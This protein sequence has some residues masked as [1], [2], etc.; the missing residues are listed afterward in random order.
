MSVP[1]WLLEVSPNSYL[2]SR[3]FSAV[4]G[5]PQNELLKRVKRG[6]APAPTLSHSRASAHMC[7][8]HLWRV[9][10]VIKFLKGK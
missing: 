1:G 9:A 3:D 4:L 2:N 6:T 7:A 10:D 8:S 5:I